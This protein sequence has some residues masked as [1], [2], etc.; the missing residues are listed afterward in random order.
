MPATESLDAEPLDSFRAEV[1]DW[2]ATN[3][4]PALKGRHAPL[5]MVDGPTDMTPDMVA[6][7][8]ALGERGFGTPSWPKEYGGAGLSPKEIAVLEEEMR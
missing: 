1:R 2:L 3:F 4:D 6:W 5:G 8:K 7:R